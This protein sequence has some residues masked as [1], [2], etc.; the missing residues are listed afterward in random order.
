MLVYLLSD[1]K[2][3]SRAYRTPK[4]TPAIQVD[5]SRPKSYYKMTRHPIPVTTVKKKQ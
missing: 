3:K 2:R 5:R 1:K 4:K